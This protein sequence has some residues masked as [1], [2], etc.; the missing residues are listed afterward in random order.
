MFLQLFV[1]LPLGSSLPSHHPSPPSLPSSLEYKQAFSLMKKHRINMNLTVDHN[2]EVRATQCMQ[3]IPYHVSR[4]SYSVNAYIHVYD[5][6][7]H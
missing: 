3:Q 6:V 4:V 2:P 7:F 5:S 1:L